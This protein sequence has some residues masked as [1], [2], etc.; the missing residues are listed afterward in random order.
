[1]IYS[2]PILNR[3]TPLK[4]SIRLILPH[5]IKNYKHKLIYLVANLTLLFTALHPIRTHHLTSASFHSRCFA[6]NTA[7]K[8]KFLLHMNKT[9]K[10]NSNNSKTFKNKS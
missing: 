4:F 1:M 8:M 10:K 2:L 3:M 5:L 6:A 9:N 7:H